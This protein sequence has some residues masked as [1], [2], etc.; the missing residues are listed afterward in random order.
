[1]KIN[2]LQWSVLYE[3]T[4]TENVVITE[5]LPNHKRFDINTISESNTKIVFVEKFQIVQLHWKIDQWTSI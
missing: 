5:S 3:D 2:V 4:D 1:M